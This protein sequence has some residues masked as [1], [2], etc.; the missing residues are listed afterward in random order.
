MPKMFNRALLCNVISAYPFLWNIEYEKGKE[1][2]HA[3]LASL[4]SLIKRITAFDSCNC[5]QAFYL[6]YW[7]NVERVSNYVHFI[8]IPVSW[9]VNII[10]KCIHLGKIKKCTCTWSHFCCCFY[11]SCIYTVNK[12][13]IILAMHFDIL[14]IPHRLE[15][16]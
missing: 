3:L 15:S 13:F 7:Y 11:C 16:F 1:C 5:S 9:P 10:I 14:C 2:W 6:S 8:F 12:W 4:I